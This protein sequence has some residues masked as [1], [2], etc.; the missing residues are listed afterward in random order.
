MRLYIVRHAQSANNAL[1]RAHS[2]RKI[3]TQLNVDADMNSADP[4]P[5][6][7]RFRGRCR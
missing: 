5:L 3:G 4:Q 6:P 1:G 2:Y 7:L